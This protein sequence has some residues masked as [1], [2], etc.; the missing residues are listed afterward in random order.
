MRAVGRILVICT[1]NVCRSPYIERR[2][3]QM[4]DGADVRIESAGTGALVGSDIEPGSVAALDA[5]GADASGF[6][7]LQ[8]TPALL[9]RADLVITATQR[10]RADA[11]ALH[12]RSLRR[13]FTLGELGD[14]LRGVD[15]RAA[16]AETD[17]SHDGPWATVVAEVAR[18][19]RGLDPGRPAEEADIPDPYRRGPEA[20]AAM[21]SAIEAELPVVAAALTPPAS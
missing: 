11:V 2:L 12:P 20:Y 9:D 14:L 15:L 6:V 16:A 4:L 3:R 21:T 1:G 19:R 10:H 13:T 5:V 7:S 18:G 17:A 8:L